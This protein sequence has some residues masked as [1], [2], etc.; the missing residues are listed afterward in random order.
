[1]LY[2]PHKL[3]YSGRESDFCLS[4]YTYEITTQ[5][6]YDNCSKYTQKTC[7]QRIDAY[8]MTKES[9]YASENCKS[10]NSSYVEEN[11][12][13]LVVYTILRYFCREGEYQS[14]YYCQTARYRSN[15]PQGET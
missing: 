1:M 7:K 4:K 15:E 2:F 6:Y 12:I 8:S 13:F 3:K 5:K 11:K 10:S 14:S 9:E